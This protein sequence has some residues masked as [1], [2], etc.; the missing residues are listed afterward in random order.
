M[1]QS[2]PTQGLQ[3]RSR[4][5][6]TED[7]ELS[8]VA[9]DIAPPA[10]DQVVVRIEAT[11]INPSD[12]GLLL[13]P[14][15]VGTARVG[16]STDRPIVTMT[17]PS[18][19]MRSLAGRIDKSMPVG[20]EGA[21]LVVAAGDSPAAKGLLGKTVAIMGG[22]MYAQYRTV[23]AAACL[24]LPD[25]TRGATW[26]DRGDHGRSDVRPI[27]HGSGG[28]LSGLAR[29]HHGRGGRLVLRQSA[30]LAGH[31]RDHAP[32]RPYRTGA[33]RCRLE[34]WPDAQQGLP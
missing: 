3:L 34:P 24:V 27:S 20:N 28:S 14:A 19:A 31:G 16:G 1:D 25:N 4:V 7:L 11:P 6:P 18:A 32:G 29:Q 9:V 8:L 23:Q 30:D 17:L 33:Y 10:A 22:A 5:K 26:Q 2:L 13:G 12:L 15:D 21:G